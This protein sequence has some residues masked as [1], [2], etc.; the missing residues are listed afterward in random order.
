MLTRHR[1]FFPTAKFRQTKYLIRQF[2]QIR[3]IKLRKKISF[4][5]PKLPSQQKKEVLKDIAVVVG[6]KFISEE[7]GLTLEKA[8]VSMLGHS[9]R[10]VAS[11][12]KT[13]IV[14]GKG[15]KK[16]IEARVAQLKKQK[17][18]SVDRRESRLD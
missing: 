12:D 8:T 9:Q 14:G 7:V 17:E 2:A 13:T 10:V 4:S 18:N 3:E 5:L 11:K 16:E 15:L 6:A 1:N